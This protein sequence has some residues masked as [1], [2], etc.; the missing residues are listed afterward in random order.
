MTVIA[1]YNNR[2]PLSTIETHHIVVVKGAPETLKAMYESV[3]TH[4]E[5]TY[6]KLAQEGAR[7]LALAIKEVGELSNQEIRDSPR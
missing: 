3:P 5:K 7:V 4:Y 6:Q 2:P 1:G